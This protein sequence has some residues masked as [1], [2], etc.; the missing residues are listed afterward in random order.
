MPEPDQAKRLMPVA[1]VPHSAVHS[2]SR[3]E[4]G[5]NPPSDKAS[6]RRF[7]TRDDA[8]AIVSAQLVRLNCTRKH[9]CCKDATKAPKYHEFP[10]RI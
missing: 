10:I 5:A 9:F 6:L 3:R 7:D 4:S 8:V 1:T 2:T